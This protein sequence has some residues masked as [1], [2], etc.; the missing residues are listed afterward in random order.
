M[1]EYNMKKYDLLSISL[2]IIAEVLLFSGHR[3]ASIVIHSLNI[4]TIISIVIIKK[5]TGLVQALSLVSLLRI[6]NTSMPIFFSFTIYWFVSLYGIM[7]FP[8]ILMMKDQSLDMRYIGLSLKKMHLLPF[9]VIIGAGLAMI[10]YDI[11]S[12]AALIPNFTL[13]EIFRLSIVMVLFIGFVEELIF[14][15]FLQQRLEEKIGSTKGLLAASLI[16][17]FMHSGYAN[18][19]EILFA[20]F[21]G[22]VLG[23]CFQ[24]TKSLP[25]VV[26]AHGVNNVILFGV[27]PFL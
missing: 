10:E 27:L 12:P 4:I 6:V 8:I 23:F 1:G 22:I 20:S 19:N 13:V 2:I 11:L 21:A 16:F 3:I 25:F 9:A 5:D 18:Y 17:G 7:F 26:I 15:S 14:R 24:R